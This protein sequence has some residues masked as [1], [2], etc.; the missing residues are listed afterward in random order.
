MRQVAR[1]FLSA[2]AFADGNVCATQIAT[3]TGD[4]RALRQPTQPF[5]PIPVRFSV[6][7]VHPGGVAASLAAA[8]TKLLTLARCQ[9]G[10]GRQRPVGTISRTVPK[11][12]L[13]GLL[14][15][16]APGPSG[17]H[18][19]PVLRWLNSPS[20]PRKRESSDRSGAGHGRLGLFSL[21][22][23]NQCWPC[24]D[25]DPNRNLTPLH[26]IRRRKRPAKIPERPK[27]EIGTLPLV[28]WRS[29]NPRTGAV[30]G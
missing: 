12:P 30:D 17:C 15:D 11:G 19:R 24:S 18:H 7:T 5:Y 10:S 9:I 3:L 2:L 22:K 25:T 16:H 27:V 14:P 21:R 20:F 23:Q 1:T 28:E 13:V 26:L 6:G 4:T 29:P 8:A